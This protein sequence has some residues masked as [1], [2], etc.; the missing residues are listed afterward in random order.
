MKACGPCRRIYL[1]RKKGKRDLNKSKERLLL[2]E[3]LTDVKHAVDS[4]DG[5]YTYLREVEELK[6]INQMPGGA[7]TRWK[8][9][10]QVAGWLKP[11]ST[12]RRAACPLQ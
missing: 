6:S 9:W 7:K 12:R 5:C 10:I 11:T 2:V 8:Y 4:T 3:H 1:L